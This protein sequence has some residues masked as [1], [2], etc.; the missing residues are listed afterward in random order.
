M[1]N[2]KKEVTDKKVIEKILKKAIWCQLAMTDGDQPYIIPLNYGYHDNALYIHCAKKGKKLDIIR[3]N[4]KVAF[5]V[6]LDDEYLEGLLTMKFQ[7]VNGFGKA[8]IIEDEEGKREALNCLT[9]HFGAEPVHHSAKSLNTIVM[10]KVVI[11]ETT[12]K[13]SYMD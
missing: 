10:I 2:K 13:V 8:Y 11:E 6:T 7:S 5:N 12:C 3:K 1:I 9:G 4:P